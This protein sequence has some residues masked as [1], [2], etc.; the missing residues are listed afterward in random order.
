MATID[1][2]TRAPY[3]AAAARQIKTLVYIV[4]DKPVL[5]LMCAAIIS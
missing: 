2:L 3:N 4:D 1:D 5:I